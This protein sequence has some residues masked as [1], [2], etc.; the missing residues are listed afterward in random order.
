VDLIAAQDLSATAILF[1][2]ALDLSHRA[3]GQQD[4]RKDGREVPDRERTKKS[5]NVRLSVGL[6]EKRVSGEG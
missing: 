6:M 5:A 2:R 1:A 3:L 4:V